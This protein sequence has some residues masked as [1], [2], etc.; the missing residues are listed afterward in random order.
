MLY[1]PLLPEAASGTLEPRHT[2]VPLRAMCPHAELLLGRATAVDLEQR[3]AAVET[4]AG[5]QTV[6]WDELVI[7]LG[8]VPRTVPVP[9]LTEHA[10]SFKS[11]AE[12][13][14]LRNHVLRA[15]GGRGSGARRGGAEAAAVLRLR[16]GR[17]RRRRGAGGAV[18]SRRRRGPLLPRAE[19]RPAPL[20]A[21]RRGSDDPA[22][23]TAEPR[24]LRRTGA[25]EARSRDPGRN[26]ARVGRRGGGRARRRDAD[27]DEHARL[28]GGRQAASARPR[29]GPPARRAR[30]RRGGRAAARP[31][32]GA[33]V[34]ARRLRPRPEHAERPAR[35]AD[36]P[37]RPPPGAAAREESPGR[38]GAVR[39]P[40]DGPGGHAR[41]VQGHRRGARACRFA[42]FSAGG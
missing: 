4:D 27:P 8:A 34:V 35:S 41:T 37:A 16:R 21:R 19:G 3:T 39:L 33:R 6:R 36:V 22:G 17:L 10:L 11:L 18:G 24:R 40:D 9:G 20:G 23:H 30:P 38:P 26:D 15:A 28:D 42:A 29:A 2:I 14:H 7:A 12:A 5:P 1:T 31:R 25:R 13:I 32:P